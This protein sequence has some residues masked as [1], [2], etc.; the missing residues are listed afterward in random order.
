M[1]TIFVSKFASI[2]FLR[3]RQLGP[4]AC[5]TPFAEDDDLDMALYYIRSLSSVFRWAPEGIWTVLAKRLVKSDAY[6]PPLSEIST[7]PFHHL[8]LSSR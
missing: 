2:S 7:S 8:F 3:R 4:S 6:Q 5:P 1:F